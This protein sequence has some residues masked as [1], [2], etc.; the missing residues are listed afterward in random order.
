[1]NKNKQ[2]QLLSQYELDSLIGS[3]FKSDITYTIRTVVRILL[4]S[5]FNMK[6]YKFKF[7]KLI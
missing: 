1:M 2:H 5:H 4:L 7:E 6:V 3:E